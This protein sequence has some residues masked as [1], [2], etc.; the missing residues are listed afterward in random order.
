MANY[1]KERIAFLLL[2]TLG[3]IVVGVLLLYSSPYPN[4]FSK[5]STRHFNFLVAHIGVVGFIFLLLGI[6]RIINGLLKRVHQIWNETHYLRIIG[7]IL[8]I[9]IG[10]VIFS[11]LSRITHPS[12]LWIST[13]FWLSAFSLWFFLIYP[14]ESR[15]KVYFFL[16]SVLLSLMC[17][18][19]G[20][21]LYNNVSLNWRIEQ[22]TMLSSPEVHQYAGLFVPGWPAGW[23]K[24]LPGP[25]PEGGLFLPSLNIIVRGNTIPVKFIT[26]SK[27]FRNVREFAYDVPLHIF[28]ILYIGDSFATGFRIGQDNLSGRIMEEALNVILSQDELKYTHVEVLIVNI[29]EPATGWFWLQEHGFKYNPRLVVLGSYI[30]NDIFQTSLAVD[31]QGFL[32]IQDDQPNSAIVLKQ[33]GSRVGFT[34]P[35]YSSLYLPDDAQFIT[36]SRG[37]R[38]LRYHSRILDLLCQ[39]YISQR[40][41]RLFSLPYENMIISLYQ[42]HKK[43]HRLHMYDPFHDLGLYYTPTPDIIEEAY[44]RFHRVLRG[45]QVAC[46]NNETD[47]LVVL[48]SPAQQ[49]AEKV[50][51]TTIKQYSLRADRFDLDSPNR[52]IVQQFE[53]DRIQYLDTLPIFREADRQRKD[54]LYLHG[55]GHWNERGNQMVGL[56]IA[57]YIELRYLK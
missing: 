19:S 8:Y 4:V 48:I 20:F 50:W 32:H 11:I 35:P 18:E 6:P 53:V 27:G 1:T 39:S 17:V 40:I 24:P 25:I 2:G 41:T 15:L 46:Q 38:F 30:G 28:R 47:L 57:K 42:D 3:I 55:D 21:F 26:N 34:T 5:Y 36:V 12:I 7:V 31:D 13:A 16:S 45:I 9:V 44:D 33:G 56:A 51:E 52:K 14:T 49:A 29:D 43:N 23:N 22:Q 10:G 54:W 37:W